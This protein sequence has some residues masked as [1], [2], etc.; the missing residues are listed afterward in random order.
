M[1]RR[2]SILALLILTFSAITAPAQN[3]PGGDDKS[4][5]ISK[6]VRKNMAPVSKDVLKVKMPRAT[7]TT[8]SNGLTVLIIEDHRLPLVSMQ[9][10]MSAAGP[11]FEPANMPGLA[12]VTAS[13]LKEGTKTK[14]SAQIAEAIAQLGASV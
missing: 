4:I 11:L 12:S 9:L 3:P 14:T 10:N 8:L 13:M 2:L 1:L 6:I 5:D 7:E